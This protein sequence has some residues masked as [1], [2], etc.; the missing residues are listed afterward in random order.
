M[1]TGPAITSCT[2]PSC[3]ALN[4]MKCCD[5]RFAAL[6]GIDAAQ[7][8]HE[9]LRDAERSSR[10][11]GCGPAGSSPDPTTHDGGSAPAMRRSISVC[12][13]G[14][15]KMK[16]A[17]SEKKLAEHVHPNQRIF[18]SRRHE[19]RPVGDQ[20]QAEVHLRIA[21]RP[22]Q[23]AIVV[24]AVIAQVGQQLRRV[25]TVLPKPLDPARSRSRSR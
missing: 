3:S 1:L 7:I 9:R 18:F 19:D 13:S 12:S 15:R 2:A 5:Q 20:R 8:Q 16:P 25:R 6:V 22:E 11:S 24:A 23:Q 10:T 17:G 21:K 14:V 4:R